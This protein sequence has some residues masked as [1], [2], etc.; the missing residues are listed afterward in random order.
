[1]LRKI[2]EQLIETTPF[3][4]HHLQIHRMMKGWEWEEVD[5]C[6]ALHKYVHKQHIIGKIDGGI[7]VK[8]NDMTLYTEYK[9]VKFSL[10]M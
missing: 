3:P 10:I 5:N 7:Y 9:D 2:T 1:M 4:E 8:F 6:S